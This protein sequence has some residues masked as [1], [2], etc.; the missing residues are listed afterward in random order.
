M[1]LSE[2]HKLEDSEYG[3]L[4]TIEEGYCPDP[5]S[6][7]ALVATADC[8]IVG[9]MLLISPAHIEG[10]WVKEEFRKGTTGIRLMKRM[11]KE[12]KEIGLTKLFSYAE[13]PEIENY[14]GRLGYKQAKVSVWTKEI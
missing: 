9:R 5:A 6:S 11:E 13:S 14:L 3:I 12:A 10:T 7:I 4:K 2:I 1:S 8:G